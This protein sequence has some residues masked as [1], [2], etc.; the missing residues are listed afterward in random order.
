MDPDELVPQIMTELRDAGFDEIVAEAQAQF[1]AWL[2]G[3][4]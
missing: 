3:Q 2:A 4:N 1:D